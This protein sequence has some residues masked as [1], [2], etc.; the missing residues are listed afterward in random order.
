MKTAWSIQILIL[1]CLACIEKSKMYPE[2]DFAE[3]NV[4]QEILSGEYITEDFLLG[5]FNPEEHPKFVPVPERLAVRPGMFLQEVVLDSFTS[6]AYKAKASGVD[7]KII[8]ATRNFNR[9][10]LIWETKWNEN[11]QK[12]TNFKGNKE[13]RNMFVAKEILKFSSMPGT[14]RHHWGTDIDINNLND[15]YFV[16]GRGKKE[17]E[18]LVENAVAFGFCQPYSN[19]PERTG[20]TEEKWHW[21][22]M[23]LT[24]RYLKA[25][26]NISY[27]NLKGFKGAE[28]AEK[29][30]VIE[31]YVYGVSCSAGD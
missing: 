8:S 29:L 3:T 31:K 17:Y 23:P 22:F 14:S 15:Q 16:S 19:Y 28:Y 9:Q 30:K 13:E 25:Y 20:Y 10:K 26:E 1:F 21:S 27:N 12:Y 2:G 4:S 24:E 18:W 6:M 7:L 11:I 5:Q